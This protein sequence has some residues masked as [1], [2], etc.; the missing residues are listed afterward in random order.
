MADRRQILWFDAMRALAALLVMASHVRDVV[1]TDWRPG[2][3][4]LAWALYI[5]TSFG[6]P[7]VIVFFVLSGYW[8]TKV[9]AE[10][11][12]G[13][14]WAW[15]GYLLDRLT[16]LWVVLLPA[17]VL[18]A[19]ADFVTFRLLHFPPAGYGASSIPADV[20]SHFTAPYLAANALFLQG[21]YA[22]AFG[23]NGP[24]WS[25]ANE[26]WYYLWFPA[27]YAVVTTRRVTVPALLALVTAM[28]FKPFLP[29]FVCWLC[30]SALYLA[31]RRWGGLRSRWPLLSWVPFLVLFY[32]D[33]PSDSWLRDIALAASAVLPFWW[34]RDRALPHGAALAR[35]GAS[36]SF[37]LYAMHFP[38]LALTAA[39]LGLH[40][41]L[42]PSPATIG[43]CLAVCVVLAFAG[44]GFSRL[45]ERHTRRVRQG[46]AGLAGSFATARAA[47]ELR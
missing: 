31:S 23:S 18:G 5:L 38:L 10:R 13:G 43:G 33:R 7:A 14:T 46:L 37:S 45:T 6:H 1:L 30:G 44:W 35:Y 24:L 47:P 28:V 9:V 4:P 2:F 11:Q 16:R 26:F 29:G 12:A 25:L 19:A 22:P 41:R 21:L 34:A 36:S 17:L 3:G 20:E 32:A 8:I 40:A 39:G 27:L 42:A 15:G